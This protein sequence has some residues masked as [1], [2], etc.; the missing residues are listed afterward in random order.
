VRTS[1]G[2]EGEDLEQLRFRLRHPKGKLA[3]GR[4]YSPSGVKQQLSIFTR[5]AGPV[6]WAHQRITLPSRGLR[7]T[8]LVPVMFVEGIA[9]KGGFEQVSW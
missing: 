3:K 2:T 5:L 6:R 1:L 7:I 4:A 9:E 8:K